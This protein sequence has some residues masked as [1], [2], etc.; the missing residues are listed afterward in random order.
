MFGFWGVKNS[1]RRDETGVRPSGRPAVPSL[2]LV[3]TRGGP[4]KGTL[5]V[6]GDPCTRRSSKVA[7][8]VIISH[9]ARGALTDASLAFRV[10]ASFSLLVKKSF[11]SQVSFHQISQARR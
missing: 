4:W 3:R 2:T 5:G 8:F 6:T 9:L 1:R 10:S 11:E 7:S